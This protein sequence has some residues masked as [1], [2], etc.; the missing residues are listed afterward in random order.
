MLNPVESNRD[1]SRSFF[2]MLG[3]QKRGQLDVIKTCQHTDQNHP[4]GVQW[5]SLSLGGALGIRLETPNG[6][7]RHIFRVFQV[8]LTQNGYSLSLVSVSSTKPLFLGGC[9]AMLGCGLLS[10][11]CS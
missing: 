4:M 6:W 5:R 10:T 2:G 8:R 7:S 1:S 3:L 9:V 11:R